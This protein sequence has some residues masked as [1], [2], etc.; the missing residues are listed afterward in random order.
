M[1]PENDF[2]IK[3]QLLSSGLRLLPRG[4]GLA[5]Y[6]GRPALI[7]MDSL[8]PEFKKV[9]GPSLRD[10][11]FYK[12]NH[13]WKNHDTGEVYCELIEDDI[14]LIRPR[15]IFLEKSLLKIF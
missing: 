1:D 15:R 4:N 7:R 14:N 13:A 11:I 10:D 12:I 6:S 9:M 8:T 2:H 3:R 5:A